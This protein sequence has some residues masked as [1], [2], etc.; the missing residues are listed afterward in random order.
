MLPP[1]PTQQPSEPFHLP[2]VIGP[3]P[4]QSR[5]RPRLLDRR[6]PLPA[7]GFVSCRSLHGLDP[8]ARARRME[9]RG[10]TAEDLGAKRGRG[11]DSFRTDGIFTSS[12]GGRVRCDSVASSLGLCVFERF[13][14]IQVVEAMS[15]FAIVDPL[16]D[17]FN[18]GCPLPVTWSLIGE[19]VAQRKTPMLDL[20]PA[21]TERVRS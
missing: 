5:F 11:E 14:G 8:A 12:C 3:G 20:A 16:G 6:G 13:D 15:V 19:S 18:I 17:C 9:R 4:T 2:I 7:Y 21:G 1:R 10:G